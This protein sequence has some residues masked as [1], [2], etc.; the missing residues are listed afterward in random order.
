MT[1]KIFLLFISTATAIIFITCGT[2]VGSRYAQETE[3][4]STEKTAGEKSAT[5][6]SK[7]KYPENFVITNYRSKIEIKES[8][9]DS[10]TNQEAWYNYHI[11]PNKS[12]TGK[13]AVKNVPGYRVQIAST[14][15]LD[16]ADSLRSEIYFKTN[17]KAIY[18]VFDPPF[19]KIEVG[20]FIDMNEAKNLSFKLKQMGY[21]EARVV[22]ETINIFE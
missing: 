10:A 4:S 11:A 1:R 17:Q 16:E 3:K 12:D 21:S 22:N 18:I 8:K 15:N 20:D 7:I 5:D 6:T 13:T 2:P 9:K 14:D 19:Y